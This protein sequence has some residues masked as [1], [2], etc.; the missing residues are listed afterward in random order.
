MWPLSSIFKSP[1]HFEQTSL[2][3]SLLMGQLGLLP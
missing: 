3:K 2:H 1:L